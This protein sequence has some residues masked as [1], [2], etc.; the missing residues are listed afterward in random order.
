MIKLIPFSSS[1][2]DTL[3]HWVDSE[4]LLVTI[5]GPVFTYPLT[6]DQLQTYLHDENSHSFTIVDAESAKKIGHAEIALTG[7]DLYKIDKLIIGDPSQRG[8]GIGQQV[9]KALLVY[10]FEQLHAETVELNVF[11]WNTGGIRCYEKTGFV[12]TENSEMQFP[13]ADKV[14]TAFNM[15]IQREDWL[16]KR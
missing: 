4:E 3:I 13:I 8:K 5:A 16:K 9:M 10:S 1:D 7:K 12:K 15:R 6:K 2:F 11:D 14:W